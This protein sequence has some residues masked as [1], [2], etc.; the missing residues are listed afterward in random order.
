M[1]NKKITELAS[2]TTPLAGTE[3]LEIVQ[4]GVNKK[5]AVS[6]V[7]GGTT[8]DLEAVLN[9]SDRPIKDVSGSPY[10]FVEEDR[11]KY[12]LVNGDVTLDSGIFPANSELIFKNFGSTN[13]LIAGSGVDIFPDGSG[14]VSPIT[15]PDGYTVILKQAEPD[16][17]F[18]NMI[19]YSVASGVSD[20]DKGDITV[21]GSGTV[22]TIDNGVVTPAKTTGIQETLTETNFGSFANGLTA[23]TTP[24]DADLINIVD[25]AD[26]NKQKKVTFTNVKAFLKTYFDTLY[27]TLSLSAYTIRANNT[28]G[29]AGATDF[30]FKQV[31]QQA[32]GGT[33]TWTAG[34]APSGATNQTYTWSQIGNQVTARLNFSYAVAGSTCT[35]LVIPLPTDMPTPLIPTGLTGA[36]TTLYAS[37]GFIMSSLTVGSS[38]TNRA[39]LRRNNADN[40]F[41]FV[42]VCASI[43]AIGAWISAIYYTN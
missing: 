4:S 39:Y 28:S 13:N 6:D 19:P 20:G 38:A 7:G 22:W 10:D 25:T 31:A 3:L 26:S 33:V 35:I 34:T 32:Y 12:L 23:K 36:N 40:G 41:E 2:A 5:V 15:I 9:V 11:G 21:S 24:L 27:Q 43:S 8:P 14:A 1:A 18:F 42:I 17:W 29:T 30:T 16:V 37:V